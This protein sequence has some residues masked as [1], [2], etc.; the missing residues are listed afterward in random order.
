MPSVHDLIYTPLRHHA[1]VMNATHRGQ[2]NSDVPFQAHYPGLLTVGIDRAE[3]YVMRRAW[4]DALR[5]VDALLGQ[6]EAEVGALALTGSGLGASLSLAAAFR[7][8]AVNAVAADTP[9]AL[10]NAAVVD[11]GLGYPLA[12]IDDYLRLN[13]ELRG[14]VMSNTAP[15]DPVSIAPQVDPPV[16]LGLAKNH[17]GQCPIAIGEE[18]AAQLPQCN[19]HVYDGATE[20]GGHEH[21]LVRQSWLAEQLAIT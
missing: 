1:L 11:G 16:L 21:S 15:L 7:R 19:L 4:G 5:S 3:T 14:A 12:E 17:Q 8:P 6:G 20:G 9:L 18:V 2:R 13:P 10:G